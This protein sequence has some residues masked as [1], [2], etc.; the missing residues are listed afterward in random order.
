M[1]NGQFVKLS[2]CMKRDW[3]GIT[4]GC[5]KLIGGCIWYVLG[6]GALG[7]M[8][9]W[10]YQFPRWWEVIDGRGLGSWFGTTICSTAQANALPLMAFVW[11]L[12]I[13]PLSKKVI[14]IRT[15]SD[16]KARVAWLFHQHNREIESDIY[17]WN[18]KEFRDSEW[19]YVIYNKNNGVW[20]PYRSEQV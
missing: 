2:H 7:C 17:R 18:Y 4:W 15:A 13:R 12:I 16:I 11:V 1:E 5:I 19:Y 9:D 10:Q 20:S 14:T 6:M 8:Q 3:M